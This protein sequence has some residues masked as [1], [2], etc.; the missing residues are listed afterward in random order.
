MLHAVSQKRNNCDL[1]LHC[2]NKDGHK[3]PR[4]PS[5]TCA[6]RRPGH[7]GAA[8]KGSAVRPGLTREDGEARECGVWSGQ[9]MGAAYE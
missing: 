6:G 7:K 1:N 3:L 4:R 8:R 2:H 5:G 9:R